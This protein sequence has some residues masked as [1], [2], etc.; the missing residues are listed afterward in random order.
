M[1]SIKMPY[2]IGTPEDQL[3]ITTAVVEEYL[4]GD[5]LQA[6]KA[7]IAAQQMHSL[8]DWTIEHRLTAFGSKSAH[9]F[10]NSIYS[11]EPRLAVVR[12]FANAT[13]HGALL[14]NNNRVLDEV[15]MAGAFSRAFSR[16]FD[17]VRMEMHIVPDTTLHT[18]GYIRN[19]K[20]LEMD[21]VLNVCLDFWTSLYETNKLPYP[22]STRLKVEGVGD[23]NEHRVRLPGGIDSTVGQLKIAE[24]M[25]HR[26]SDECTPASVYMAAT[27]IA[28]LEH[29]G[30][31]DLK[32]PM[33]FPSKRAFRRFLYDES[34][35]IRA[36]REL[37]RV[38]KSGARI[39][40]NAGNMT[41]ALKDGSLF[42]S[43]E[44]FSSTIAFWQAILVEIAGYERR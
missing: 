19:G 23:A 32:L 30:Y 11:A 7:Q 35:A 34:P 36:V 17:R 5:Q 20:Y 8:Q 13:K 3:S 14:K 41:I 29:W 25:V 33:E 4:A 15:R 12:D 6:E 43:K 1:T 31:E 24:Q 42:D 39:I 18:A 28:P 10:R 40:S 26:S 9:D 38:V 37:A 27:T 21:D 16:E 44:A 22:P 2:S